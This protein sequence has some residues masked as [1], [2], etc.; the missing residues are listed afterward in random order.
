LLSPS[1]ARHPLKVSPPRYAGEPR[2]RS[3]T[4]GGGLHHRDRAWATDRSCRLPHR[5]SEQVNAFFGVAG[6][7][8]DEAKIRDS[9]ALIVEDVTFLVDPQKAASYGQKVR[10]F[11][12]KTIHP[13]V[14]SPAPDPG[15]NGKSA[16]KDTTDRPPSV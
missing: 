9:V 16:W 11:F 8:V 2:T 15:G 6:T 12:A 5:V 4:H 14:E 10:G 1:A 3:L 13:A 7:S